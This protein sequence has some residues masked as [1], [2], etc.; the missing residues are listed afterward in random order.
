MV[1]PSSWVTNNVRNFS[2]LYFIFLLFSMKI[3]VASLIGW[4]CA[5]LVA[6]LNIFA[7]VMKFVPVPAGS[8]QEAMMQSMGMTAN[9]SHILGV[10]ELVITVLFLVPKTSTVGFVL[11]VGY[12]GGVLATLLTHGQDATIVYIVFVLLMI[13]AYVR[14]PELLD[15]LRGTKT[16]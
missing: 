6:A 16:A 13:S 3:R 14:N 8:E 4:T 1:A 2:A 9:L 5:V 12:F 10:V 11:I 7:G 15:R